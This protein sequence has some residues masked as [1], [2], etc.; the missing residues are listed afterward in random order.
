MV[1][2]ATVDTNMTDLVK[3]MPK[4]LSFTLNAMNANGP[5]IL[6]L[7]LK[8]TIN[9][10][11]FVYVIRQDKNGAMVLVKENIPV[12]EVSIRSMYDISI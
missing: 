9:E 2:I 4:S 7:K 6:N 11:S 1:D 8:K 10:K 5:I 3:G 12:K